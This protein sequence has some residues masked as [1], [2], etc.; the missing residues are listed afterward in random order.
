MHR[1]SGILGAIAALVIVSAPGEVRAQQQGMSVLNVD[2]E[3]VSVYRDEYGVPHIFAET[4]RALFKAYGYV[5]A[6]DRLWQSELNRRAARGRL[7]EILGPGTNPPNGN[8]VADQNA[9]RLGYTDA[10]L[11]QQFAALG[12]A[13]Q[14]AFTAYVEGINRYIAE[15]VIPDPSK[16]LPFEFHFLGIGVPAAW[17]TLDSFAT[18]VFQAQ[19]AEG[20][21]GNKSIRH[22]SA[23]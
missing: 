3:R 18:A 16:K 19:D 17:T 14:E 20:G 23:T 2:G 6:Q 5:V 1:L 15:I 13:Q 11:A 21:G 10:E 22:F 8:L 4:R 9:R 12:V 7:A